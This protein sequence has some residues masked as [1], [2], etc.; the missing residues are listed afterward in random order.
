MRR[1]RLFLAAVFS[2]SLLG[3]LAGGPPVV[4]ADDRAEAS[5]HFQLGVRLYN[6]GKYDEA[7]IEF[8]RAYDLSPH[9]SVLY[10]I[11]A[12]HRELSHYGESIQFFER[13]LDQGRGRLAPALLARAEAELADVRARIGAVIVDVAPAGVTVT[14]DGRVLGTTPMTAPVILGPG[15]HTFVLRAPWGQTETRVVTIAAGDRA[16]VALAMSAPGARPDPGSGINAPGTTPAGTGHDP[17]DPHDP[18]LVPGH[19]RGARPGPSRKPAF[20]R[21]RMGVSASAATN[22]RHVSTTGAPELGAH[23]RLGRVLVG[24]DA[25]LVAWAVVPSL[26]VHLAGERAAIHAIL[27]MPINLADDGRRDV[28]VA[29]AAGLGL[30]VWASARVAVRVEALASV[31]GG[32]HGFNLPV[33]MGVELWR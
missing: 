14:V 15:R 2:I 9:P 22:L 13:F 33:S 5:R 3:A 25:V 21:G 12:T 8:Q 26:R 32:G 6:E 31:A 4:H 17:H 7:L 27:A 10:N 28:F 16:T 29:G 18:A 24:A 1:S 20:A 11:A 19:G 30:R 23:L